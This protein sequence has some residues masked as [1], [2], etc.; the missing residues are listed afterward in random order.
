MSTADRGFASMKDKARQRMIAASGGKAAQAKGTAHRWT[1]E[2][3]LAASRKS[4]LQRRREAAEQ[5]RADDEYFK[6]G[7]RYPG[8]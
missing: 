2:E 4:A 1:R 5:A 8:Q 3:A 7:T 6:F